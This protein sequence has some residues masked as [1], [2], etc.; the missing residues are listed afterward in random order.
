A[1]GR[2]SAEARFEQDSVPAAEA[3]PAAR[4]ASAAHFPAKSPQRRG[5]AAGPPT[6]RPGGISRCPNLTPPRRAAT[7]RYP[8]AARGAGRERA[9][10]TG[11]CPRRACSYRSILQFRG[12]QVDN[13]AMRDTLLRQF[14][15]AWKLTSYHLNGLSTAECL[16]RPAEVGLH[17]HRGQD[18]RWY[19]DWPDS[20]GYD[21]GPPSIAWITWHIGFWW[22]M[23]IDH[24]FGAGTLRREG[25]AWPGDADAVR[26]SLDT[27]HA[28]WRGRVSRL[29]DA[30]LCSPANT[31]WPLKDRPFADVIAWAN[32]E[33]AK[34]VAEIGYARFL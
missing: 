10:G 26:S 30:E 23:V 28:D 25:I 27:L 19:G 13:G 31:R 11:L 14:D 17:V 2:A 4:A 15:L 32:V 22:S 6:H 33:L 18:G 34:N 7:A 9:A 24:S 5:A 21:I 29:T 20:E 3:G 12:L 8:D 1:R 16:W